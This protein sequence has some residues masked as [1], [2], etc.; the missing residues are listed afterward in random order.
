M[1]HLAHH[2]NEKWSGGLMVKVSA[3]QPQD[4]GLDPHTD[5]D[6]DSLY[7]TST[8]CVPESGLDSDL[9]KF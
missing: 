7:D 3:S 9:N 4:R 8:G 5:D 2:N 6:H 1:C